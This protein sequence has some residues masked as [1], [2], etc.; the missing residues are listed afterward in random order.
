MHTCFRL[1]LTALL[2]AVGSVNADVRLPQVLSDHMVLQR[3]APVRIWGWAD[4]GETVT[5]SFA[6]QT[7]ETRADD[8]G[9]W[10]AFLKPMSAGGPHVLTVTGGNRLALDD[11]LI[12]DVWVA[13]GQSNMV[14]PVRRSDN[15]EAEEAAANY[16][17]LRLFKVA[18]KV[19]DE[20]KGRP[21]RSLAS[22]DTGL[23]CR[24][25]RRRLLLR[26]RVAQGNRRTFWD[27]SDGLGRHTGAGL[28]KPRHAQSRPLVDTGV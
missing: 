21:R 9:N 19:A 18:L 20:P 24:V 14:W 7:S 10:E 23:R 25:L 12:G 4:P 5:V 2:L 28:D 15:P 13:S 8:S 1:V 16:P 6:G 3:D 22:H 17:R 27:H 26:A 11:V